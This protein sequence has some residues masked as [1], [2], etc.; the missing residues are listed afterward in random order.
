MMPARLISPKVGLS[1]LTPQAAAGMRIE[2][3]VSVPSAPRTSPLA[4]AAAEPPLLPPGTWLVFQGL[5]VGGVIVPKANSCVFVLQ[6]STLP[7]SRSLVTTV[8]SSSGTHSASTREPAVVRTPCVAIRSLMP[9]GM[10]SNKRR[11]RPLASA[12]SAFTASCIAVSSMTVTHAWMDGS[13]AAMRCRQARVSSLDDM[14]PERNSAAASAIVA[15]R[16]G[17]AANDPVVSFMP[18]FS[19]Y[20]HY[21]IAGHALS[22]RG[23]GGR[24]AHAG[25]RRGVPDPCA[26]SLARVVWRRACAAG[27]YHRGDHVYARQRNGHQRNRRGVRYRAGRAPNARHS[28]GSGCRRRAGRWS[29]GDCAREPSYR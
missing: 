17:L 26:Q 7:A 8:A 19:L 12:S 1:P 6:S 11:S 3:P 21:R 15:G 14:P 29:R 22:A 24:R 5:R 28:P 10:P 16:F 25:R 27:A 4:T 23:G 13:H 20:E 18:P 2:P 9:S